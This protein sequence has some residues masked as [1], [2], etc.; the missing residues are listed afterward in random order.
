MDVI[1]T[2]NNL[3]TK[4]EVQNILAN[5]NYFLSHAC[6]IQEPNNTP[7]WEFGFFNKETDKV[8]VFETTPF[9]Q[10]QEDEVLKK[11]DSMLKPLELSNLTVSFDE[12]MQIADKFLIEKGVM[13]AAKKIIILQT[14]EVMQWNMTIMT[15]TFNLINIKINAVTGEIF[16]TE[17]YSIYDLGL[18]K[19]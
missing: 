13:T 16:K 4:S 17:S 19:A 8:T 2:F 11:D 3:K 10:R 15:Q 5:P 18:K 9:K 14:E 12:A 6:L 1:T 7:S